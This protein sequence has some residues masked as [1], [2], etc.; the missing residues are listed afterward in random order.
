MKVL[1]ISPYYW[2][3]C[4]GITE[5]VRRLSEELVKRGHQVTVLT[6]RHDSRLKKAEVVKGVSVLRDFVLFRLS[7]GVVMPFFPLKARRE[8]KKHDVV[9][10]QMPMMEAGLISMLLEKKKMVA[11][12]HCDLSLGR[13]IINRLIEKAYYISAGAALKRI[14]RIVTYTKDYAGNSRFLRRF[15]RKLT[16]IYPPINQNDFSRKEPA[17]RKK[18]GIKKSEKAVGFAGRFVYEKGLPYLLKAIPYVEE[19]YPGTKFLL[20]GEHKRVAGGSI[21]S[22]LRSAIGK[23]VFILGNVDYAD[24]P[25]FYSACDVLVLPSISSLEAF[26]MVQLEAMYCATPVIATNLP[27]VRVP[28]GKTGMGILIRKRDE[29]A[30]ARAVIAVLGNKKKYIAKKKTIAEEFGIEKTVREYEGLYGN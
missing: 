18:L 24:L 11:T 27:G 20:A 5:Y 22:K 17:L 16:F 4:S 23:N 3:Y 14:R 10:I 29:K 26:G 25:E 8:A 1:M 15:Y 13:G 7:K 2:P 30:L 21:F 19:R 28:I 12:Y 9:N 6:S